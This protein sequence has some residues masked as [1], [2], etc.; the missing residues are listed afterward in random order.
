MVGLLVLAAVLVGPPASDTPLDPDSTGSDGLRG[1]R[2]LL[3]ASGAQVDVSLEPPVDISTRAFVPLDLLAADDRDG[4]QAWVRAGGTLVVA[5]PGSRLHG[6]TPAGGGLAGALGA[7]PRPP[8]CDLRALEAVEE[9]IHAGWR[10]YEVPTDADACFPVGEDGAWL[11]VRTE[12]RGTVVALG[13]PDPFTNGQL[14]RADNA[15]LAAALLA[16]SP[17]DRLVIVPRPAV[18]GGDTTLVDLVPPRIW[19]GLLLLLVAAGLGVLWRGRRLGPPVADRLPPVVPAAELARSVADLL[20]RAGSRDGAARQLRADAR[21]DVGARLGAP[22]GTDPTALVELLAARTGVDRATAGTALL[23]TPVTDDR[24]LVAI[25][26]AVRRA[27]LEA[28][29]GLP[30]AEEPTSRLTDPSMER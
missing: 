22:I 6:L 10:G 18:G 30:T 4:W 19:R 17:G 29:S 7:T 11:V 16:P 9:V 24:E 28:R 12:G 15:V 14:D 8:A 2:D 5:D 3:E 23:D 21:R 25:A 13:A 26:R 20:Q 27:R 1:V